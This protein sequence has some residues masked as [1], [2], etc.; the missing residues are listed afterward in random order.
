MKISIEVKDKPKAYPIACPDCGEPAKVSY[1]DNVDKWEWI[2]CSNPRC[3]NADDTPEIQ[4]KMLDIRL[5]D[6]DFA[7][8]DS[9]W[10]GDWEF[11]VVTHRG[12][13]D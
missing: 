10:V 5:K 3:E 13:N 1:R 12:D 8:G 9:F 7:I 4:R 11:E 6:D 2:A